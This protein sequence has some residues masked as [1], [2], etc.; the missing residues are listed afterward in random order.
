M[1]DSDLITPWDHEL[2]EAIF[3]TDA[4]QPWRL[5]EMPFFKTIYNRKSP[6]L[7]LK[8]SRQSTKTTF[9]RN[10]LFTRSITRNNNSALYVGPTGNQLSDFSKKK[11]DTILSHNPV[12][13][14]HYKRTDLDWNV[15]FKQFPNGSTINLRSVGGHNGAEGI[16]GGTYN[17]IFKDEFQSYQEEDIPVIDSCADTFDGKNGRP[18]AYY[19]NTGTPLSFQNPIEKEWN[20]SYGFEWLMQCPHCSVHHPRHGRRVGG[21]QEPIGMKH[22]DRSRPFLFCQHCGK[23]M[24]RRPDGKVMPPHGQWVATNSKGRFP[25][26][27]VVRLMMPWC[28]WRS[29]N[30]DGVLDRM[31][32]W[33]ERQFANE[34]MGLAFESGN[35][36]LT[37]SQIKSCCLDYQLPKS[38]AEIEQAAQE[39][40]QFPTFAGLDW[41]MSSDESTPSY[42]K[43]G[44]WAVINNRMRLVFAHSFIGAGAGDPDYVLDA[45][46]RWINIFNITLLA[47]DYGVGYKENQRLRARHPGKVITFH[48]YGSST[49]NV[50]TKYDPVGA[51]YML[52]RTP[53][54]NEFFR[55]VASQRMDLP[56]YESAKEFTQDWLNVVRE[57]SDRTRTEL[58]R[59]T[60]TDD[61]LH[62]ANYANI[63]KRMWYNNELQDRPGHV[64][65]DISG[66]IYGA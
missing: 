62:V 12:L 64:E 27:R 28:R 42:T 4:G 22:I 58:I 13:K 36:P 14:N 17:D 10:K 5:H 57:I 16:R 11:F 20:L 51:K 50:R 31:E 53:S 44:V 61:F 41:A 65:T 33:G 29:D 55:A 48:Y 7:L 59:R 2:C 35:A 26:Y 37:E 9:V 47:C 18:M 25:G 45:I 43:F 46:S 24:N 66:G 38:G 21:W 32:T 34:V 39:Y 56:Q 15:T 30:N 52:P 54:L 1:S 6:K 63:A 23:D 40:S 8:T 3:Y 60:G 19:V 49:G